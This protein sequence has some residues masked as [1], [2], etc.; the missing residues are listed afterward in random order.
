MARTRTKRNKIVSLHGAALPIPVVDGEVLDNANEI[1]DLAKSGHAAG[2]IWGTVS[3]EGQ[4][5]TGFAGKASHN[6]MIA[7]ATILF[8]RV[9]DTA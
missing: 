9:T 3:P 1:L 7:A 2:L 4:I 6:S 5:F 8:R